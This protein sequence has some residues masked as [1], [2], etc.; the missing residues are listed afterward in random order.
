ML[1]N[2]DNYYNFVKVKYNNQIL[3]NLQKE[4]MIMNEDLIKRLDDL[5][6]EIQ[7]LEKSDKENKEI[8]Y[9]ILEIVSEIKNKM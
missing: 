4:D 1:K 3:F 6:A 5:E 7:D 2:C 9:K 8:L